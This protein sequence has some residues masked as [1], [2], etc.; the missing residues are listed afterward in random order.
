VK[1]KA[2]IMGAA[3][4]DFHNFNMHF[5][6]NS[7]YEVVAFTA[8]QIPGIQCSRF[9]LSCPHRSRQSQTS[10]QVTQILKSRGLRVAV[11]R[12][13]MP[14]GDLTQQVWQRFATYA[15]LDRYHCTIEEREEYAP[16]IDAGVV[17]Y[18]GDD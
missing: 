2:I 1:T 8:A 16:H 6:G 13:P 4:R 7:S 9:H 14:Y 12:H 11:I 3:G 5:R 15:D 18:A 17:I 10:R